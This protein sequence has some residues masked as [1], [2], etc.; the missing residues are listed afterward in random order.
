MSP[1]VSRTSSQRLL[2]RGQ[3]RRDRHAELFDLMGRRLHL[4]SMHMTRVAESAPSQR[5]FICRVC[6]IQGSK[7]Q[8][9]ATGRCPRS[10]RTEVRTALVNDLL[11]RLPSKKCREPR[12]Q[13]LAIG[14]SQETLGMTKQFSG[15]HFSVSTSRTVRSRSRASSIETA[16]LFPCTELLTLSDR[17]RAGLALSQAVTSAVGSP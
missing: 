5:R 9:P 16:P 13:P 12:R 4:V 14:S 1:P 17:R 8:Q 15:T 7:H 2:R 10:R 11:Q 3:Q 6:S